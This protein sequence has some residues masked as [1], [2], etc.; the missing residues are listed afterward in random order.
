MNIDPTSPDQRPTL[1]VS[2]KVGAGPSLKVA[3]HQPDLLPW[4][5]FWFK[6]INADLFVLAVHD[7]LQKHWVQ[8]RVRMR[9]SWVSLSLVGKP[10][11]IPINQ[12]EVQEGWQQHLVAAIRGRYVG[13]RHWKTRGAEVLDRINSVHA[14][15]LAEI[16]TTLIHHIKDLLHIHTPVMITRPPTTSG[17]DRVIE[18]LQLVGATTYLSGIGA[19]DYINQDAERRFHNL[20]INLA[21]SDHRKTTGDSIVTVLMDYDDPMEVIA[22]GCAQ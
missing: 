17:V 19:R 2:P 21:W 11:L 5:G 13:A 7:Q 10:R 22:L 4:S 3:I 18:Q 8:R 20:G 9:E 6:M 12:T 1:E 15:N 14:T 16:N